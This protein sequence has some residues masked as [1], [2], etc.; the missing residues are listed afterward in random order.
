MLGLEA[1]EVALGPLVASPLHLAT[2]LALQML[3]G[4][5]AEALAWSMGLDD[6]LTTLTMY[7]P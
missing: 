2:K 5:S 6:R 7:H 1:V 4:T 3:D